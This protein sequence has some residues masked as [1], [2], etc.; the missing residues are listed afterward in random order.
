M[1]RYKTLTHFLQKNIKITI[2]NQ[3]IFEAYMTYNQYKVVQIH[4]GGLG[5]VFLGASGIP[6]KQ[7]EIVLNEHASQGWQLVFQVIE[8]KRFLLFWERESLIITLGRDTNALM[9]MHQ[10]SPER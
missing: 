2:K 1:L 4:E 9:S 3:T 7:M 6:T 10:S 8:K 5:T